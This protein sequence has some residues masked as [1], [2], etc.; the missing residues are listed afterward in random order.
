MTNSRLFANIKG[1][2]ILKNRNINPDSGDYSY[3]YW[4]KAF[5]SQLNEFDYEIVDIDGEIPP[6]LS[7]TVFRSM[8]ARFERGKKFYFSKFPKAATQLT[9]L[10]KNKKKYPSFFLGLVVVDFVQVFLESI[11][12][13]VVKIQCFLKSVKKVEE[14]W[15]H[16]C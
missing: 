16:W 15:E 9:K 13:H 7:G 8:P 2:P 4:S 3:D 12:L 14:Y 5:D 6:S 1:V 10:K 11:V